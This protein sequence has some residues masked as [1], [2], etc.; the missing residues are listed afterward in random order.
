MS[1]LILTLRKA[2][3]VPMDSSK[4]ESLQCFALIRKANSR[5]GTATVETKGDIPL[6]PVLKHSKWGYPDLPM[7]FWSICLSKDSNND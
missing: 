6:T 1:S 7:Q 2:V 3:R 4:Q 5:L